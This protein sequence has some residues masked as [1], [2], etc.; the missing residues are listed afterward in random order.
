MCGQ[1]GFELDLNRESEEDLAVCRAAID[2]YKRI[3]HTVHT[4]D[5]YRLA[6][7]FEGNYTALQFVEKDQSKIV[8]FV[9]NILARPNCAYRTIR[10]RGLDPEARYRDEIG[11]IYT[12]AFL[13]NV[14]LLELPKNDFSTRLVMLE[15]V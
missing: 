11:D 2:T 10:L 7:P 9:G 3:R 8:L 13:M 14:G 6:N 12:G 5:M 4:G 15:R 1:F